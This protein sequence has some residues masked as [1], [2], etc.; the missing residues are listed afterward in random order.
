MNKQ[1]TL[2]L[3]II[4]VGLGSL[5]LYYQY[6]IIDQSSSMNPVIWTLI[7]GILFVSQTMIGHSIFEHERKKYIEK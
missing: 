3:T 5:Y 7:V 6:W 1:K 2:L 4:I